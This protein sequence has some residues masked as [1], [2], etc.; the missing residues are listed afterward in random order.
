MWP[1]RPGYRSV[2]VMAGEGIRPLKLGEIEMLQIAPTLG[3]VVG[4]KLPAAK[5]ASLWRQISR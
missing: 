2:F 1:N 4:V 3:D 5:A